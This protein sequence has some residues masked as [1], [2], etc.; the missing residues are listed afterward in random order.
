[1]R[2]EGDHRKEE[3]MRKMGRDTICYI[4][5]NKQRQ[6]NDK[7]YNVYSNTEM[8]LNEHLVQVLFMPDFQESLLSYIRC[9]LYKTHTHTHTTSTHFISYSQLCVYFQF[10]ARKEIEFLA[11]NGSSHSTFYNVPHEHP[12]THP[13][14]CF[15]SL[16]LSLSTLIHDR[17]E[18]ILCAQYRNDDVVF[19]VI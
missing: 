16:S 2:E 7:C 15:F 5:Q 6:C 1:M 10:Q 17:T 11:Y 4:S 18:N 9:E 19:I 8:I 14:S 3:S 12:H 13:F